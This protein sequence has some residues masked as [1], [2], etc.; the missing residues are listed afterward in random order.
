MCL[1][2]VRVIAKSGGPGAQPWHSTQTCLPG[3][4]LCTLPHLTRDSGWVGPSLPPHY[5]LDQKGVLPAP[6]PNQPCPNMQ[7]EGHFWLAGPAL[8]CAR[9]R[10]STRHREQRP[11]RACTCVLCGS[12]KTRT[13]AGSGMAGPPLSCLAEAALCLLSLSV[14]A[15]R[16]CSLSRRRERTATGTT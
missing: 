6:T 14:L 11:G 4:V 12:A 13:S 9:S 15:P 8:S 7:A 10:C 5:S 16:P 1:G 2:H 3:R